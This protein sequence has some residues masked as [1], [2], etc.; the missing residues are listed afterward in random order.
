[1][2]H[3]LQ[4]AKSKIIGRDQTSNNCVLSV[5]AISIGWLSIGIGYGTTAGHGIGSFLFTFGILLFLV[6][7]SVLSEQHEADE[8]DRDHIHSWINKPTFE[9][10]LNRN[11]KTDLTYNHIPG[12]GRLGLRF[13]YD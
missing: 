13:S 8:Q 5:I 4:V 3:R 9:K 6:E 10:L 1:M 2:I 7:L 12:D 11:E